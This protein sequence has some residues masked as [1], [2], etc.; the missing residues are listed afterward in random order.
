MLKKELS[1]KTNFEF[2]ISRKYGNY[3]VGQY[4]HL[5]ILKPTNYTGISKV[6]IVISA[7]F[8]KRAVVRNKIKRIYKQAIKPFLETVKDKSF[9]I[10]IHPKF[11]AKDA[12]YEE[13]SND[14]IKT[15]QK[16]S[17]S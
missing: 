17:I 12:T 11:N 9:W 15:L 13:I 8:D 10:V 7:K 5:Y 6:G 14:L 16:I 2:N 4:L 3:Y 1:L